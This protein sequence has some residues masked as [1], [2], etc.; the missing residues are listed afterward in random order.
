MRIAFYI[1]KLNKTDTERQRSEEFTKIN[2]KFY[3]LQ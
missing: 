1:P 2:L 3:R